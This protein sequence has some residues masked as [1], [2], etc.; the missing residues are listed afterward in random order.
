MNLREQLDNITPQERCVLSLI[1][2]CDP[3]DNREDLEILLE[4]FINDLQNPDF[5]SGHSVRSILDSCFQKNLLQVVDQL[6]L[7]KVVLDFSSR[8]IQ[9]PLSGLPPLGSIQYSEQCLRLF[10]LIDSENES[11]NDVFTCGPIEDCW[12]IEETCRHLFLQYDYCEQQRSKI[13]NSVNDSFVHLASREVGPIQSMETWSWRWW[14]SYSKGYFF[15][16][17]DTFEEAS[18]VKKSMTVPRTK[19]EFHKVHHLSETTLIPPDVLSRFNLDMFQ[20]RILSSLRKGPAKR[21][22]M[23][24]KFGGSIFVKPKYPPATYESA[25]DKCLDHQ[26]IVSLSPEKINDIEKQFSD[27]SRRGPIQSFIFIKSMYECGNVKRYLDLSEKG[28]KL[29]RDVIKYVSDRNYEDVFQESIITHDKIRKYF[30][31]ETTAI[32]DQQQELEESYQ[33]GLIEAGDI[34][35]IGPWASLW[36]E[37]YNEGYAYDLSVS[38]NLF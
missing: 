37:V 8:K 6:M 31:N 15:D 33:A 36:W 34:Y 10:Q 22:G 2:Q 19:G 14:E 29:Y 30:T 21:S 17:K 20:W 35:K 23:L 9:G 7:D 32:E 3:C 16:V 25:I 27:H 4:Y 1:P 12:P 38:E 5:F 28:A 26:W 24:R 13:E 11:S 18:T